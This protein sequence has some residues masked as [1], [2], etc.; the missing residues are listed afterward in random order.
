M[1]ENNLL[2]SVS[3][4][5][6]TNIWWWS[7]FT[8]S[9]SIYVIVCR[10][11]EG[12]QI[13]QSNTHKTMFSI[14]MIIGNILTQSHIWAGPSGSTGAGWVRSAIPSSN[15]KALVW[16]RCVWERIIIK[17]NRMN[18]FI[19]ILII[20]FSYALEEVSEHLQK[21]ANVPMSYFRCR[22]DLVKYIFIML[23]WCDH[24]IRTKSKSKS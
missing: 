2:V 9:V 24:K 21:W 6:N 20:L 13:R 11:T 14:L 4:K 18:G 10:Q 8:T 23:L 5:R 19:Y 22:H 12:Q 7:N 15:R 3:E 17:H 1:N 16:F